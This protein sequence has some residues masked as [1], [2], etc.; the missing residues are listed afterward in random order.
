MTAN[1]GQHSYPSAFLSYRPTSSTPARRVMGFASWAS[2]GQRPPSAVP[3]RLKHSVEFCT[4]DAWMSMFIILTLV[5]SGSPSS[6]SRVT[7]YVTSP[8]TLTS[9]SGRDSHSGSMY[10]LNLLS[11]MSSQQRSPSFSAAAWHAVRG[12]KPNLK[13]TVLPSSSSST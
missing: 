10:I 6:I 4:C 13:H 11:V 5:F 1:S 8:F 9:Y 2:V 3:R 12:L 7:A